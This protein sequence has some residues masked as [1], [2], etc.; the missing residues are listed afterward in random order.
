[1]SIRPFIHR[2]ELSDV[3]AISASAAAAEDLEHPHH[4]EKVQA[5]EKGAVVGTA[6]TAEGAEHGLPAGESSDIFMGPLRIEWG[7]LS[8]V[9]L[10][11]QVRSPFTLSVFPSASML[12]SI[13]K[14]QFVYPLLQ[15]LL[16]G[17]GSLWLGSLWSWNRA[18]L[19]A[20]S[21]GR[22]APSGPGLLARLGINIR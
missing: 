13:T 20:K 6:L 15:G 5:G 17:V 18:R 19:A 11:D 21:G 7:Q 12:T 22:P 9:I 2:A 16:W 10:R 14:S 1:M 4:D 8:Y 3:P